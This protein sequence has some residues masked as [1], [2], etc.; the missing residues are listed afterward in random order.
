MPFKIRNK[1]GLWSTGGCWPRFTKA[2]KV[3][4]DLGKVKQHLA[5]FITRD[6]RSDIPDDWEVVE[7]KIE[8]TEGG[9]TKA[10]HVINAMVDQRILKEEQRQQAVKQSKINQEK[11]LLAELKA[12]YE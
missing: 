3:W 6:G 9:V 1:T 5:Q 4:N 7:L 12:K 11:K 8:I 10:A 2:G